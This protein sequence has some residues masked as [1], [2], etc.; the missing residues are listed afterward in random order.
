MNSLKTTIGSLLSALLVTLFFLSATENV[1]AQGN[2]LRPRS[3]VERV[4]STKATE[5]SLLAD[6]V[7]S[8]LETAL[9]D[10]I[11]LR[12]DAEESHPADELYDSW[13]TEYLKAY[14]G[15]EIPET[16]TIDVSEFVMPVEGRVTSHFG[17]RSRYRRMHKGTD[18][19]LHTGDTIVAAF[20][21]KVRV[22][23]YDK[24][25]FGYYLVLRH[26]N[27]L[28]TVYGHLSQFI[29]IQNETVVAGQ[30]IALGGSTGRSTGPHLHFEFRFLGQEIN[31]AEIIDFDELCIKD[32]FYM[33]SKADATSA[34]QKY[35][36][37]ASHA[38]KGKLKYHRVRK[39]ET[40]QTIARKTG[41]TVDKLRKLN[42]LKKGAILHVGKS[43]RTS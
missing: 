14:A 10:S 5:S 8:S 12:L 26:A 42:K 29:A 4:K 20:D 33:F 25:G 31:P 9:V 34:S 1:Q 15:V 43:L 3:E 17:Y 13:N 41:T 40:L 21:G 24:G 39:G 2:S 35:T 16:F 19:A 11:L 37:G 18:L 38:K 27:G 6:R 23:S 28:E 32:D 7:K 30:P 22:R 36:A